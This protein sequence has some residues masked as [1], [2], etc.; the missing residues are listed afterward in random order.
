MFLAWRELIHNKSKFLLIV[1]L[2]VLITY[3]VYFLISLAYG[4][5]SSYTNGIDKINASYIVLSE[6]ANDNAMMSMLTDNDY[7]NL[8]ASELTAKLGLFPAVISN[9]DSS[10]V[11]QSKEEVYVFGIENVN[12]FLN[13]YDTNTVLNDDE[14]IVD[15][16]LKDIGYSVG[17]TIAISGTNISWEIVGFTE[18]STYQTA[19]IVYVGLEDWKE[20]RFFN[21]SGIEYYNA[22]VVK[23]DIDNL[24]QSL[25]A[26]DLKEFAATLPGYTAQVLTFSLM[27]GFLIVIIAFVLGIFI[28][29]LTVQK[30]PVFGVMKAQG[31][32]SAYIGRSVILQ[33]LIIMFF[34]A[35]IGLALTL[36]SGYFLAGVVPFAVN[37]LFYGLVTV[38]FFIFSILGGLFSVSN[39]TK[40]DPLKAIK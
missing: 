2:I 6:E 37:Y 18:K 33:T 34:G 1:S 22:I 24:S 10:N 20:Y 26:Y 39:I 4:L 14:I 25:I 8:S 19:P 31:I 23:G 36:L 35:A 11:S 9:Q 16:S 13:E 3:L 15:S 7:N 30:T 28:Y 40:I 12:F 29:V 17:D 5:A 32:S 27:I 38:A 21:Q